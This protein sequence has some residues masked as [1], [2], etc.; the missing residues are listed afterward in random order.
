M[1]SKINAPESYGVFSGPV[2]KMDHNCACSSSTRTKAEEGERERERT[3]NA[4]DGANGMRVWFRPLVEEFRFVVARITERKIIELKPRAT[5]RIAIGFF[6]ILFILLGGGFLSLDV[7]GVRGIVLF[8]WLWTS[9]S[10]SSDL[11]RS[12]SL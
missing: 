12:S 3:R 2:I 6:V 11:H 9:W 7:S 10:S 1:T 8:S 5:E 4:R